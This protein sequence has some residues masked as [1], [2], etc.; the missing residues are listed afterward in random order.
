MS[1]TMLNLKLI[2][3]PRLVAVEVPASTADGSAAEAISGL[4]AGIAYLAGKGDGE[5]TLVITAA[6]RGIS[7]EEALVLLRE[8][9]PRS[10][11]EVVMV[12]VIP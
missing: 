11:E 10:P 12:A 5:K 6:I 4:S 1:D 9:L 3:S 8:K 2:R 7:V